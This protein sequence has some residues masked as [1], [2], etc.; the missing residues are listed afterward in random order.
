MSIFFEVRTAACR[1]NDN[2]ITIIWFKYI[3]I[4][5][6][7]LPSTFCFTCMNM[8]S[9]TTLLSGR[10]YDVTTLCSQY[11]D[12]CLVNIAV[13]LIHNATTNEPYTIAFFSYCQSNLRQ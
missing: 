1:V 9:S 8:Q 4:M 10:C 3:D 2:C 6:G 5:S 12:C 11:A 13:D 7:K